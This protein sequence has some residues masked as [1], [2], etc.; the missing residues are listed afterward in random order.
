MKS[1]KERVQEAEGGILDWWFHGTKEL[2]NIAKQR[3]LEDRG[4]LREE[5]GDLIR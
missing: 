4:A 1:H 5:E 3:M 2:W